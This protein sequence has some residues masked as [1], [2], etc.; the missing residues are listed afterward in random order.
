MRGFKFN[1]MVGI[2]SA[3]EGIYKGDRVQ[4]FSTMH[5]SSDNMIRIGVTI[6]TGFLGA[7]KTTLLNNIL[8]QLSEKADKASSLPKRISI[9][10][11]EFAAAI[12]FENEV[13]TRKY[14]RLENLYEFGL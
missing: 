13:L 14:A 2:L 6:L 8:K 5:F 11:N 12:G 3:M 10:E 1:D 7:G 4:H 9:I